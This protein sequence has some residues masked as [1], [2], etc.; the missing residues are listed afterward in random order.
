M[1]FV[2]IQWRGDR[3]DEEI[4][5]RDRL[6][7]K[8]LGLNFTEDQ[9]AE[10]VDQLHFG[11]IESDALIACVVIVPIDAHTKLRQM[12][13]DEAWQRKGVGSRLVKE[14]EV[15]LQGRGFKSIELSARVPV[16]GFYES[17]GYQADGERFV[18]VTIPHQ[19]MVKQLVV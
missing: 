6:L 11:L 14:V 17:L 19:K 13:V 9:L 1:E 12:A 5:L 15:C 16:V 10:E 4:A 7:R 2:Q 18:E 8:P 3:Y